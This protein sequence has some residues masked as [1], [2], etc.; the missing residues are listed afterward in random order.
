MKELLLESYKAT[1]KRTGIDPSKPGK[2][3]LVM[4]DDAKYNYYVESLCE[5][6]NPALVS[7][8]KQLAQNTRQSLLENSMYGLNPYESL[9]LP[10]L[11]VFYPKTIAKDLVTVIPMDKPEIIRPFIR[12]SFT[13]WGDSNSYAA[14]SNVDITGGPSLGVPVAASATVGGDTDILGLAGL[15]KADTHVEKTFKITTATDSTSTVNINV[16]PTVDGEF[17][18]EIEYAGSEDVITGKIDYETGILTV[19]STTGETKT[20]GFTTTLSLEENKI[21]PKV[22]LSIEKMRL[23]AKDRE[24]ST[25]WSPQMEQDLKALYDSEV[26]AEMTSVMGQQTVLDI[27]REIIQNLITTAETLAGAGHTATFDATPPS[28]FHFGPKAW[29][30]NIAVTVNKLSA[31]IYNDTNMAGANVIA[32]N[33]LD[34]VI[35]E[36]MQGFKYTGSSSENGDITVEK[37]SAG[38]GK[39]TVLVSSVVAKG[40]AI[41]AYKP[42]EDIRSCYIFAPYVPAMLTPYPLGAKPSLT[43]LSR[44]G[45]QLIRPNGFSVL[46]LQN[47]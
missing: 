41:V 45:S 34:A 43:L 36:S 20:I 12:A 17:T 7:G 8:F 9:A 35:F 39:F 40:K 2:T 21:N 25:E 14:P 5:G 15:T 10:M 19:A 6:L 44:Y 37:A 38:N 22:K 27:D 26:Q 42:Q 16:T 13:K 32:C 3:R 11:R 4:A 24:I 31:Q 1:T 28:D 30:E 18:S 46:N 33:P 29:H 23:I 47:T